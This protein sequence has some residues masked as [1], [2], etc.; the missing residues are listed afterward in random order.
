M[1]ELLRLAVVGHTNTGKT[2][3]LRTLGR[4]TGF[5]TVSP[6]PSTTRHVEGVRLLADGEAVVELFDT[7][8][9][10][11][12]IGLLEHIDSLVVP[13]ERLDGPDRIAR[14]LASPEALTRFEQEAKVLR[15]LL[16]SDAGLVVID[17]RDPVLAKYRDELAILAACA[18]P[19]LPVLNFVNAPS[20]HEHEWRDALARLG[21]H[22]VISFDTVA[23][24][25]DGEQQL[26]EKLATLLDRFR[27]S[28]QHLIEARREE[29]VT[30]HQA[31]SRLIATLLI[32][33][34]ACRRIVPQGAEA[35]LKHE[36]EAL[37]EQIRQREQ[38]CVRE[39]LG[40]YRFR[41]DDVAPSG[42]PLMDGR[43]EDDLFS[44]EALRG[45]GIRLSK[46]MVAGAITGVGI[47]L[48]A[49]GLTLGAAALAGA[50]VGGLWQVIGRY[51]HDALA[52]LRGFRSLTVDDAI[53]RLLALRQQWLLNALEHRGHAAIHP[54]ELDNPDIK[55][56]RSG[57]LPPLLG[58]ARSHPEWSTL[59]PTHSP[60]EA[61]D[62]AIAA[63]I[64]Q[65]PSGQTPRS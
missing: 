60:S 4:D 15:Q 17:V 19:L 38:A 16:A 5:G 35:T 57:S 7:P 33:V 9:M 39:L 22:A 41:P 63:L 43:W 1:T 32:D 46:G 61:L 65:L 62:Q 59:N 52:K 31:A 54:I 21:L 42:L 3:L 34:A 13:G 53:L 51:G 12:A 2:S 6:R 37:R 29:A 11:D 48:V 47:D 56:W 49:G 40:L 24:A 45:M 14:F 23:P 50:V 58:K 55:R 8:G 18:R 28:L 27:P 30:R 26:L 20:T 10:E 25:L 36:V 44:I 64:D